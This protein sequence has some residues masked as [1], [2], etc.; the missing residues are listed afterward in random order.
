MALYRRQ[1]IQKYHF[2]LVSSSC[3]VNS[4]YWYH[5]APN[6]PTGN[7]GLTKISTGLGTWTAKCNSPEVSADIRFE[8]FCDLLTGSTVNHPRPDIAMSQAGLPQEKPEI[9]HFMYYS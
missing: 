8:I 5:S 2:A 4:R 1:H 6:L 7:G 9:S 3:S